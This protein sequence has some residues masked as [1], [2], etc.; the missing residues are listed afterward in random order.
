M[1][2]IVNVFGILLI[3]IGGYMFFGSLFV[4]TPFVPI[5]LTGFGGLSF[6]IFILYYTITHKRKKCSLCNKIIGTFSETQIGY[7]LT[8]DNNQICERCHNKLNNNYK[9]IFL[10][11]NKLDKTQ[12]SNL[13][14]ETS[15]FS[16]SETEGILNGKTKLQNYICHDCGQLNNKSNKICLKC[17]VVLP[18]ICPKC[19]SICSFRDRYCTQ[20]GF[21][22]NPPVE[23][24]VK[25][26]EIC[27]EEYSLEFNYCPIDQV[28]LSK[29]TYFDEVHKQEPN[30]ILFE[31][32][33]N[34]NDGDSNSR[35]NKFKRFLTSP[36]ERIISVLGQNYLESLIAD[37]GFGKNVMI[38]SDRN[39]YVKGRVYPSINNAMSSNHQTRDSVIKLEDIVGVDIIRMSYWIATI[40]FFIGFL[41]GIGGTVFIASGDLLSIPLCLVGMIIMIISGNQLRKGRR[42]LFVNHI[43]GPSGVAVRWYPEHEL[44][45]FRNKLLNVLRVNAT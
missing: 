12:I 7:D 36:T 24:I 38:L 32:A 42:Y 44:M 25:Y 13:L 45:D 41:I 33:G 31:L 17:N 2:I 4:K 27:G 21:E 9:E 28:K 26:C 23:R 5:L 14:F 1:R 3:L 20:C 19:S 29:K 34:R 10:Q 18:L 39:L 22:I 40:L 16:L 37:M 35:Y 8:S 30:D 15:Q 6:G 11:D 43:G